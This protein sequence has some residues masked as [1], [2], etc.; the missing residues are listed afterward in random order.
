MGA[1]MNLCD[2]D[3]REK[4]LPPNKK[5]SPETTKNTYIGSLLGNYR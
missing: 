5:R 3:K 4:R 2:R 1:I